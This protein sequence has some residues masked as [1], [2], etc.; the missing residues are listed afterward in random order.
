MNVFDDIMPTVLTFGHN[1]VLLIDT[2]TKML[3]PAILKKWLLKSLEEQFHTQE[4]AN[5]CTH[6]SFLRKNHH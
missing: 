1:L 2:P 3:K 6:L 4:D 5:V